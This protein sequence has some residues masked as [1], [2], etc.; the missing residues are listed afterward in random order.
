MKKDIE[1]INDIKI[2]IDQFYKQAT[3]DPLIGY[4]F[5]SAVKVNWEKHL[6]IMYLFW[7]NILFY[8][9][10]YTGNPM[11]VHQRI[12]QI[13][14][15]NAQHFDQWTALFSSTVDNHFEGEKAE[16]AK[17]RALSIATVMKVKLLNK[18]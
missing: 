4:I 18:H 5:T 15:L 6:P 1:T 10:N 7:E 3:V 14:N 2:L 13:V 17:Q 11:M 9:G 12:H 8:T 16:L